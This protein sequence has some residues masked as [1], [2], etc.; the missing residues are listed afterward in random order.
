MSQA[1]TLKELNQQVITEL[2]SV[3][4]VEHMKSLTMTLDPVFCAEMMIETIVIF[5]P[6]LSIQKIAELIHSILLKANT[7]QVH[8]EVKH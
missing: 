6:L 3:Y 2:E 1:P 7:L 4:G 8:T 5:Y